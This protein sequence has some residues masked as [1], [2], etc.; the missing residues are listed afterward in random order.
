MRTA[1]EDHPALW[2]QACFVI[3]VIAIYAVLQ[4]R[5]EYLM[6]HMFFMNRIQHVVMHHLGPF[7]IALVLAGR[8]RGARH[9][10]PPPEAP[11]RRPVTL[12]MDILQQPVIAAL[13]FFGLVIFWL[14][15]AIHFRAMIDPELYALMNWTMI[16]DGVLFWTLVL[17]PRPKP[18]ARIR[19][20]HAGDQ[21]DRA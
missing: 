21:L 10:R 19:A 11:A 16:L 3:G 20:C 14:I 2:R 15:P 4:T 5:L 18:P 1:T 13:L 9:A 17:D 6:T 7:L 12:V 8:D